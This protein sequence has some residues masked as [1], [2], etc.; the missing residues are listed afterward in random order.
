MAQCDPTIIH[1]DM[2]CFYVS[3][4]RLL[5]PELEGKPVAV[6]GTPEG[7]GVVASCSYEARRFGVRSAMPMGRAV[8]LCPSLIVVQG[9]FSRYAE[10]SR[11]VYDVLASFTPLVQ[12][13]SQ[14]EA[15]LDLTGTERLWGTALAAAQLIRDRVSG[16]T[17]LPCSLGVAANKLVAKVA[18]G[19]AKPK[20][21]LFIPQGSEETFFAPLPIDYLPGVGPRSAERLR[22]L[23]IETLGQLRG[24]SAKVLEQ[25]FGNMAEE[26]QERARG[27]SNSPVI[28]DEPAKSISAEETF[29]HDS[30]D[31]GFLDGIL[32]NL[33]E[34]VAHRLRKHEIRACTV[35]L[36]F[37]YGDFETHTASSTL[38][39]PI[40]DEAEMLRAVRRL[41][42]V[43]WDGGR[44]L[45]LVGV[46]GTNL[47]A[48]RVQ[49]DL[50]DPLGEEKRQRLHEAVDRIRGKHGY[51]SV[52][53]G[54]SA[55]RGEE[56]NDRRWG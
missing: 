45:R 5:D 32:S 50:L 15:Y 1:V 26:L 34:K 44:A 11:Q 41:L 16:D 56:M 35:T 6:G 54:S 40:D 8:Q 30:A 49:L 2:D 29:D 38:P 53:R 55:G 17:R 22:S 33:C 51:G 24:T 52:K 43:K 46:A 48:D 10:F 21:L 25:H 7:R 4:E 36:K 13:A 42:E 14:D 23:G 3:V 18:S 19:I 12:M 37:R 27:F 20:G 39:F 28:T 31:R 47:I 9:T